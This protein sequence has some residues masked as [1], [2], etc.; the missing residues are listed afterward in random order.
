M[1]TKTTHERRTHA[2]QVA[3]GV[4]AVALL[5]WISTLGIRFASTP[6]QTADSSD[7]SQLASV[8]SSQDGNATLMV[9]TSSDSNNAFQQGY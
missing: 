1:G 7:T 8:V 3:G 4:T 6:P 9:A 5:I 2:L